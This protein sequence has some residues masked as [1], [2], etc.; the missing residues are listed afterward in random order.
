[1]LGYREANRPE[2]QLRFMTDSARPK[3][4]CIGFQKTGTSSMRDAMAQ[5]GFRV[6]GKYGDGL[7][8]NELRARYV[9]MG[10][11]LAR[12]YDVVQDMPWPLIY[13]ELDAA[14][15][16]AKFILTKRDLDGWTN[17][18]VKHFGT[19]TNA[20]RE[21]IYGE[22]R[23]CPV[24]NEDH[25]KAV[26]AAHIDEVLAY[27]ADRPKDFAVFDLKAGDGW[28]KL[29][30]FLG[31]EGLPDGPFQHSNPAEMR[32]SW[33][34]RVRWTWNLARYGMRKMLGLKPTV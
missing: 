23:G 22:G 32:N 24:G 27:F 31:L 5:L 21:L 13:R 33:S 10:L 30:D 6:A 29:G 34:Y 25:Y 14:F 1:M 2:E 19:K 9:E 8:L 17:S 28:N 16:G 26:H 4:F 15:P 12:E 11:E 18:M 3:V 20:R 7:S